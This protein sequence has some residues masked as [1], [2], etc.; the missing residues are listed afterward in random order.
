MEFTR[1]D[2]LKIGS[3]AMVATLG[4]ANPAFPSTG[5]DVL[6]GLQSA[7]FRNLVGTEFYLSADSISSFARLVEVRDFP[8]ETKLSECFSLHFEC[9]ADQ[10]LQSTYDVFHPEIGNFQLMMP[11]GKSDSRTTTMVATIN[12][13]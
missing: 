8:S 10:P 5:A 3:A 9:E 7:S 12:R 6:I 1:R 2:F 13:S 4:S 11:A